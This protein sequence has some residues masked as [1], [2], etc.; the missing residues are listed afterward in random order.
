M[1]KLID[2]LEKFI[3][4]GK[5]FAKT[6]HL[7]VAVSG[8]IDSIVLMH[9][10]HDLSFN[11]SIAHCNFQ[12]RG[13]DSDQDEEMVMATAQRLNLAYHVTRFDTK[14]Y[15]KKQKLSTQ[16]A[17]RELRY[18]WFDQLMSAHGYSHLLTAHHAGDQ[19]E[20]VLYN[21]SKGTGI[22]GLRGIPIKRGHIARP[23]LFASKQAI[24]DYA[25]DHHIT[26]RE[27]LSNE[28]T[29][30]A[31]NKIRHNV[32]PELKKINSNLEQTIINNS[33]HFSAIEKLLMKKVDEIINQYS[34]HEHGQVRIELAWY[35]E[36][37]GG[38]AIL[39]E[40]LKPYH[41]NFQQ[42]MG[43]GELINEGTTQG[44]K[45]FYSK[46]HQLLLDRGTIIIAN[47]KASQHFEA[48]WQDPEHT[49]STPE[50]ELRAETVSNSVKWTTNNNEA[51]LDH[52][53]IQFPLTIRNWK[54]GDSFYPLGMQSKKKLSDFM[55][56][57][58]IPLNLK[59][60]IILVIS[61]EEVIWVVGHRI[62]NRYKMTSNTQNVL[63]LKTKHYV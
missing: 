45:C 54:Q 29:K 32:V 4:K 50:I 33:I 7:L 23:L 61:Q 5:L 28:S 51:Y 31:R 1:N 43:L 36:S 47:K 14:E 15:A 22:S 9:L 35:D 26:W 25:R 46:S 52:D 30:Y 42:C 16:V 6:D 3:K 58:K 11:I 20:T 53:K 34:I 57:E 63:V 44:G 59:E 2:R 21:L 24:E 27:D 56:D 13:N 8:G 37:I 48:V 17:A 19:V 60:K 49:I 18:D 10:L 55:I 39:T 38:L 62:D 41:F 12:L 40:I